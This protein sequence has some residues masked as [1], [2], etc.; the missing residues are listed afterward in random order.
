VREKNPLTNRVSKRGG[1]RA[2]RGEKF[3][4]GG[5]CRKEREGPTAN[6]ERRL[7]PL[8]CTGALVILGH[9]FFKNGKPRALRE[10]AIQQN[11]SDND[12]K[13]SVGAL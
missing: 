5:D 10:T 9:G 3:T 7:P 1:I 12:L 4:K 11:A 8:S 2:V 13:L 6:L